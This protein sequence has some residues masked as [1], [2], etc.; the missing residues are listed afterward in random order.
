MQPPRAAKL[1][2]LNEFRRSKP[3]C[4]ASALAAIL[5]DVRDNGLPEVIDRNPMRA[6]RDVVTTTVGQ[7]G[8]IVQS[9]TCVDAEGEPASMPIAC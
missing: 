1:R 8:P 3:R 4:T 5:A 2:R 9:F 7:Y 6:A